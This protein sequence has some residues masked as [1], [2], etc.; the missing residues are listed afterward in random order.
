M[1]HVRDE[2]HA[3]KMQEIYQQYRTAVV[4]HAYSM[5]QNRATAEDIC[6]E[7]FLRL[8]RDLHKI[9]P[10]KVKSWLFSVSGRLVLDYLR[11][12]GRVEVSAETVEEKRQTCQDDRMEPER[13]LERME[14]AGHMGRP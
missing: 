14:Q 9:P 4:R 3:K 1:R 13:V 6:Q 8:D 12:M 2:K 7:T 10:E 5:L 11:K